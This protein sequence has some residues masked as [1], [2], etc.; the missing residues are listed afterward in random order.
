MNKGDPCE[1]TNDT[2]EP[3]RWVRATYYGPHPRKG[4][5][6]VQIKYNS[7]RGVDTETGVLGVPN[8]R[9]QVPSAETT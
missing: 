9:F 5:H 3:R 2:R 6:I 7:A 4:W 8:R 1:Y